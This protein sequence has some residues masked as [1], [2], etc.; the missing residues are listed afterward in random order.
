[1]LI[2]GETG[3]GK[4]ETM[5]LL[6]YQHMLRKEEGFMLVYPHGSLTR[7]VMKLLREKLREEEFR[8]RVTL[9]QSRGYRPQDQPS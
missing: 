6:I 8:Q 4:S 5:K 1:M 9:H 7:S 3:S 2:A